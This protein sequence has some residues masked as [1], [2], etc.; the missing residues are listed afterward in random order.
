[1]PM[2]M[3]YN[4]KILTTDITH[5]ALLRNFKKGQRNGNWRKRKYLDKAL[6]R[7]A[8]WYAKHHSIANAKLVEKLLGIIERLRE[9]K[10]MRIF[11]KGLE[12]AVEML[13]RGEEKGVFAWAPRLKDRLRD[14]SY[15]LCGCGCGGTLSGIGRVD[16]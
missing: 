14:K 3:R 15:V 10:G 11:K 13:G 5:E 1:M 9:T 8:M 7:A 16:C 6:Y 2:A 12:K 4:S